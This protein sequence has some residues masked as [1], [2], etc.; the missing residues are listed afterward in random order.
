MICKHSLLLKQKEVV[1]VRNFSQLSKPDNARE[2]RL[3]KYNTLI[4]ELRSIQ[5]ISRITK[6]AQRKATEEVIQIALKKDRIS[7]LHLIWKECNSFV[8]KLLD[9][10]TRCASPQRFESAVC[11][12]R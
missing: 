5:K 10:S 12:H 4:D 1:S 7:N 2:E 9:W 3:K 8:I 6:I 11:A